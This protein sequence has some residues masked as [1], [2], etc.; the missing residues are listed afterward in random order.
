METAIVTGASRGLGLALTR[1]LADKGWHVVVDAR[2][3]DA[4]E[5]EVGGI[6]GVVAVAGDVT[7]PDHRADL[8]DAVGELGRLDL[9]VNNASSSARARCPLAVAA[10]RTPARLR[11]RRDRADR[12]DP[13]AGPALRARPAS[14]STS[15]PT[16]QWRRTRA[17]AATARRRPR[18][19]TRAQYWRQNTPTLA[20][21]AV[22]PGDLRTRCTRRRSPARTSRTGRSPEDRVPAF[23]RCSKAAAERSLPGGG[24]RRG[25][26]S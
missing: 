12:P 16:P 11:G 25:G 8:A 4:V 13:G 7:D 21:Y 18:W 10:R 6:E 19:T 2:D 5:R 26:D 17:G 9:L 15:A 3:G 23:L 1:A 24:V 20:V 22:D 14:C